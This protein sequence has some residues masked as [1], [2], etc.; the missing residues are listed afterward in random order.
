MPP[1]DLQKYTT[2]ETEDSLQ[3]GQG[4]REKS[5]PDDTANRP[6]EMKTGNCSWLCNMEAINRMAV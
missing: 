6:R 5:A 2:K 1:Q 4:I 3:G